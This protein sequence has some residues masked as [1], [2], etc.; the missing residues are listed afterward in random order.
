M[1]VE[2]Y[3]FDLCPGLII[4]QALL[5]IRAL[6]QSVNMTCHQHGHTLADT[7]LRVQVADGFGA[8]LVN[9]ALAHLG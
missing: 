3:R 4:G 6:K 5:V 9:Q 2:H 8:G 1:A 7:D